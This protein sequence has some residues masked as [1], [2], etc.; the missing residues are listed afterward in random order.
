MRWDGGVEVRK[1]LAYKSERTVSDDYLRGEATRLTEKYSSCKRMY[2]VLGD[3]E[4]STI[5][6]C[7]AEVM[8]EHTQ[9]RFPLHYANRANKTYYLWC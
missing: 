6:Q 9:M 2:R 5:D 1:R 8:M 3:V 7:V 4:M